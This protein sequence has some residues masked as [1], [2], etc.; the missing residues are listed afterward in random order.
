MEYQSAK[1]VIPLLKEIVGVENVLTETADLLC[2]SKDHTWPYPPQ[3]QVKR[4]PDVVV[5]PHDTEEVSEVV[6][7]ANKERIPV[8]PMGGLTGFSGGAVPIYGGIAIDMKGMDKMLEIDA[9]NMCATCEAGITI[10]KFINNVRKAGFYFPHEV[11]SRPSSTIG[12]TISTNGVG[13]KALMY[14]KAEDLVLGLEIVLAD[15]EI[16]GVGAGGSMKIKYSSSGYNLKRLFIGSFGTLGIITKA[17]LRIFE[18]PEATVDDAYAFSDLKDAIKTTKDF[19]KA[20]LPLSYFALLHESYLKKW[21]QF[22]SAIP[23]APAIIN[24]GTEG[25][26]DLVNAVHQRASKICLKNGGEKIPSE[27]AKLLWTHDTDVWAALAG[28]GKPIPYKSGLW[29]HEDGAI[30]P[31]EIENCLLGYLKLVEKYDVENWG[32]AIFR[33]NPP[34]LALLYRVDERDLQK[35][36]KY[37]QFAE[38]LATLVIKAGGTMTFSC[39][40]GLRLS[41]LMKLEHGYGLDIMKKIKRALDPNNIMN[42]GKMDLD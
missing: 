40:V 8:T 28:S 39:G 26:S 15:G 24:F 2:Y 11:A 30:P 25:I 42:P 33:L 34:T 31:T 37:R 29:G 7:L 20:N 35:V 13:G 41:K 16:L 5:V 32:C 22:F 21:R 4:L 1:K 3:E 23:V 19:Y 17:T 38:E 18:P 27:E 10:E 36:E 9:E 12:G 6:R 14:G